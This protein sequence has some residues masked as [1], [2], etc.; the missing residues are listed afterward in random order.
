MNVTDASIANLSEAEQKL[1]SAYSRGAWVDLRTGDAD[2]DQL[3]LAHT[4]PP[5]RVV[6]AEV[7]SALLLGAAGPQVGGFP[8][9]RLRGARITGRLDLTGTT[10]DHAIVCEYCLFEDEVC[11]VDATTKTVRIAE[12][13]LPSFSGARMRAEG[14]VD[15]AGSVLEGALSVDRAAVVGE[16]CLRRAVVG[17]DPAVVAVSAEGLSVDGLVECCEGFTCT[18]TVLLRGARITGSLDLSGASLTAAGWPAL[19]A[20]NAVIGGR[21]SGTGLRAVGEVRLSNTRIAGWLS[22]VGADL[23]NPGDVALGAGGISVGGGF[24]CG[25][26]FV[27]R[28]QVRLIGAKVGGNLSFTDADLSHPGGEALNLDRAVLN[29]VDASGMRVRDSWVTMSN[30]QITGLASLASAHLDGGVGNTALIANGASVS[31]SFDLRGLRAT[32]ELSLR[33][34]HI[35]E[36]L[37]LDE[38]VLDNAP[39]TAVRLSRARIAA[40][41]FCWGTTLRGRLK[42]TGATVGSDVRLDEATLSNPGKVALD[43]KNLQAGTLSLRPRERV[44]GRVRLLGARLGQLRDDPDLWPDELVLDGLVYGDLEPRLPAR[45]RLR[46]LEKEPDGFQPPPYEQLAAWYTANGQPTEARRVRHA[47]ERKQRATKPLSSR[48]WSCLQ[49]VTIAY[50]Y[51]PWRAVLWFLGLLIVGSTTYAISAP[52]ALN[53]VGAPHF[54]PVVYTLDLLLPVV[55]LGQRHAYNPTGF[56]QWLSYA[57]IASGW[58]LVTTI[59]AAGARTLKRS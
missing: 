58:I 36:R 6:R 12:S 10:V 27:A 32:G 22:L 16:L 35:S 3:S 41:L 53:Q 15:F 38:A 46:W 24:W 20:D 14:I 28:G 23:R 29:D 56:E 50:G 1:W 25:K 30:A 13:S 33:A 2:T 37:L 49:D 34:C 54:N 48:M 52:A 5:S 8:A 47:K 26:S 59:A 39:G 43:A 11:F 42:L 19:R 57:L 40:D 55:D 44:E 21:F 17:R 9:L 7:M 4:W 18:G 31:G 45:D 51:Q